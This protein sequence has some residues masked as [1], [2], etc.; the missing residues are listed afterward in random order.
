M[1]IPM[2]IKNQFTIYSK[3][4]CSYCIKV[5]E[6]LINLQLVHTIIDCDAYIKNENDRTLFLQFIH[7][8]SSVNYTT[9]PM[10]FDGK[11]FVGGYSNIIEYSNHL[12]DFDATF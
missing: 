4:G 3:S 5:K 10:I 2:P 7:N 1:D 8:V 11:T 6:L 12:L 9:F